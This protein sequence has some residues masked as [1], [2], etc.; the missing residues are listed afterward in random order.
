MSLIGPRPCLF[1]QIEL[2]AQR[3]KYKIFLVKPGIT[4]LGQLKVIDMSN[5]ERLAETD[6]IMIK[7]FNQINTLISD[8]FNLLR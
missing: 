1:N 2:I 7:N 6:S 4:G 5:P 3:E 8:L